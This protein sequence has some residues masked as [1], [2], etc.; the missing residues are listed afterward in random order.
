MSV[1]TQVSWFLYNATNMLSIVITVIYWTYVFVPEIDAMSFLIHGFNSIMAIVDIFLGK[2]PCRLLHFYQPLVLFVAYVA[3][4]LIFW[5]FGG[6]NEAGLSYIYPILNWENLRLTV[7]FVFI[8]LIIGL[9]IIHAGLWTLHQLRDFCC[10]RTVKD[11]A[12][13]VETL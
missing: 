5:A 8:G 12:S 1:L 13:N 9:P 2:K 6:R 11:H 10:N 3:F 4:S 7:P